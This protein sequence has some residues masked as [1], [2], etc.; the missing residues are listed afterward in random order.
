MSQSTL[1]CVQPSAATSYNTLNFLCLSEGIEKPL[2]AYLELNPI[3]SHAHDTLGKTKY[4]SLHLCS[5]RKPSQVPSEALVHLT[6]SI[7]HQ[8]PAT[9]PS[10][11]LPNVCGAPIL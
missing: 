2:D 5:R 7:V 8:H 10:V 6:P 1:L 3:S 11:H 9:H 4:V